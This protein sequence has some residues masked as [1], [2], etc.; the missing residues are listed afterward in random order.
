MNRSKKHLLGNILI[1]FSLLLLMVALYPYIKSSYFLADASRNINQIPNNPLPGEQ[2]QYFISVPKIG[3]Y[4]QVLPNIDPWNSEEYKQALEKGVAHAKGTALPGEGKTS[5]LFAHSSTD[6]WNLTKYN[7]PFF[8]LG[9][10]KNGDEI[11][12]KKDDQDLR[13][14]VFDKKEVR[15]EETK[16]LKQ[17]QGDVL[18]LQTCTPVGTNIKRLLVFARPAE[19]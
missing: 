2:I 11:I 18:I 13:Y 1:I 16:Y 5:F 3:A 10:L 19:S 7:T 8:K 12:V 15:P 6:L 4:A 14:V 17:D 9:E